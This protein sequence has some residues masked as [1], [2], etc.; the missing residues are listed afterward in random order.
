[1]GDGELVG[2]GPKEISKL[3]K[4]IISYVVFSMRSDTDVGAWNDSRAEVINTLR[5]KGLEKGIKLFNSYCQFQINLAHK[6]EEQRD[7]ERVLKDAEN[8][9][10]RYIQLK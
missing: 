7:A 6:T 8:A 2:Y 1:M 10:L 9:L 3:R 4:E 5:E